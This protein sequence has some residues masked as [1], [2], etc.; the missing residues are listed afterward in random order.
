MSN[1]NQ[2]LDRCPLNGSFLVA[3]RDEDKLLRR[4]NRH[5]MRATKPRS[6][7]CILFVR[8]D[9]EQK[10]KIGRER[11]RVGVRAQVT[12]IGGSCVRRKS[13]T[14][15]DVGESRAYQRERERG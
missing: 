5:D 15:K 10:E 9:R 7:D 12:L 11:E 8:A 1:K 4:K 3:T 14:E 2:T 13:R 6:R